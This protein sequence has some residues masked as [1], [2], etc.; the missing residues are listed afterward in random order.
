MK[1]TVVVITEKDGHRETRE[2]RVETYQGARTQIRTTLNNLGYEVKAIMD[3]DIALE[4]RVPGISMESGPDE[5][6]A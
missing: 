1:N 4:L 3:K 2:F 5:T 6:M